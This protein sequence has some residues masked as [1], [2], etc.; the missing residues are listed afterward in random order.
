MISKIDHIGIA[1]SSLDEAIPHY[2]QLLGVSCEKIEEVESQKVRTGFFDVGGVHI[3]LLEPTSEESPVAKFIAK[4][5]EGIHHLA[6]GTEDTQAELNRVKEGGARL[7]DEVPRPGANGKM[8]G[9]VHPKST[10]G[11]LT[12]L[13]SGGNH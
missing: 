1:V 6:F 9:F 5:G 10:H 8:I 13:C 3:E 12:E 7:I 4:K 11:V 2:E